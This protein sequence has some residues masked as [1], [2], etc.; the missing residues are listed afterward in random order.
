LKYLVDTCVI[1]EIV[2]PCPDK[3]LIEWL[4]ETP[5][6]RL[7]LSVLTVGEIRKGVSKLPSSRKKAKLTE[8]LNTLIEDYK[9]RILSVDLTVSE[10]WGEMQ[11]S[12]EKEGLTLA[13]ID[14]LIASIARTHNLILVTRNENDFQGCDI[15]LFNPWKIGKN[16]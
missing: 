14:G 3:L 13:T 15:P 5:S 11:S 1:S 4:L 10:N 8:W 6:D 12:A 7:Y 9:D 16:D 2:K